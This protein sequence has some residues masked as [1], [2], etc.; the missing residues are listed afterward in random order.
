MSMKI[1]RLDNCGREH[2][3]RGMCSRHWQL[4]RKYGRTHYIGTP[5]GEPKEYFEKTLRGD[6]E[7]CVVWP[8]YR[9]QKGYA[10]M[11][12][13][14]KSPRYVHRL[15]LCESSGKDYGHRLEAAHTCGNGKKGCI[16]PKHLEWKTRTENERDKVPHGT[17]NRGERCG[18]A[19]LTREEVLAIRRD[20]R[21]QRV[22]A[23]DFGVVQQTVADIKG[24]RSWSWL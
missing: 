9:D 6:T 21:P 12:V 18:N 8:Y 20:N 11:A 1:C 24:R 17:S 7:H 14:G 16:N 4:K 5:P 2:L 3:S 13:S 23:Q 22:V 10:K 19:K 15:V